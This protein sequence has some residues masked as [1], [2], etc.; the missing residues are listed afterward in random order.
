MEAS[1]KKKALRNLVA[2]IASGFIMIGLFVWVFDP[3]YQYHAPFF[4]LNAVLNDRD[5]QMPGTIRNFEYDSVLIGSSVA[6]NFDS[7]YLDE[8][9]HCHTLKLIR[10]SGSVADLL[11]YLEMAQSEQELRNVFWCLDIF[12]IQAPPEVTLYGEDTPRYLHT[13]NPLDDIPYLYNKEIIMEKIPFMLACSYTGMNT[14]GQAY[15]WARG[16][17][18]SAA[19]AMR[20]Y[21]RDSVDLSEIP[22]QGNREENTAY[23]A[24]NISLLTAQIEEH[25]EIQYRFLIPPFSMLWWDCAYVNGQLEERIYAL[26]RAVAALLEYENTAIYYF[27]NESSI[28]CGL[29]NYMDMIHYS[30]AVNQY[31][32]EQMAAEEKKVT[33]E[34]WESMILELRRMTEHIVNEEIYNYYGKPE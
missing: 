10:G 5:N 31:M 23:V 2:V 4:G 30:P 18:F 16:K 22:E 20:A 25:P 29:D 3:F 34:N 7:S 14:G 19:R 28:V 26:D 12:A 15:N 6:E 24:E 11:Y 17:E 27:Q 13:K 32:L 9:Y 33:A 8:R 21:D 1:D